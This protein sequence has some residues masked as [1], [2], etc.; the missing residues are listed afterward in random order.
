MIRVLKG[1]PYLIREC[2]GPAPTYLLTWESRI[3]RAVIRAINYGWLILARYGSSAMR[4]RYRRVIE[5]L[6]PA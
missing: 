1:S 3:P 5:I 6:L 4:W 2:S